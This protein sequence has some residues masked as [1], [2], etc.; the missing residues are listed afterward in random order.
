LLAAAL[1]TGVAQA[2]APESL[3][4]HRGFGGDAQIKYGVPEDSREA[5]AKAIELADSMVYLDMD[6]QNASDG[7]VVMHDSTIDR[8]T[9]RSGRIRDLS[10]SYIKGA[11]LELPIDLDGNGND[12][13]TPYHPP[14]ANQAAAFLSNLKINGEPVK[15][16]LE[17]K[18]GGWSQAQVNKLASVFR[19]NNI[20]P[21]RILFHSFDPIVLL[22]GEIAGFTT[23]GYLVVGDDALPSADLVKQFGTYIYVRID[24]ITPEKIDEYHAAGLMV[25]VWTLNSEGKYTTA[26]N[27]DADLWV[28]DDIVEAQGKLAAVP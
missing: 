25:A 10:L 3:V 22:R 12:D 14:S 17:A 28:C 7:M 15:I 23:R 8:T 19:N 6:V 24:R 18:G 9:N 16:A 11:F 21:S 1:S 5:W 2:A 13:N 20:A 4:A 27:I 26:L